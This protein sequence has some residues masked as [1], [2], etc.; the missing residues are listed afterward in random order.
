MNNLLLLIIILFVTG[1]G[2]ILP[3][4]YDNNEYNLVVTIRTKST[5]YQQDCGDVYT[6]YS[7]FVDL[8]YLAE[9][10]KNYSEYIPR[11][12]KTYQLV[13]NLYNIVKRSYEPYENGMVTQAFCEISLAQIS[14][15]A[16]NIQS[17]LGT[18]P[19]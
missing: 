16:A 1:C 18:K 19:R 7:N 6:T 4:K 10:L 3:S 9:L 17:S 11:N 8:L 12:K 2:I 13:T 5:L 15:A 14:R